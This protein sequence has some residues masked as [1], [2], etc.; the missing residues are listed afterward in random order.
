MSRYFWLLYF[1]CI[2]I[3]DINPQAPV[4]F[5]VIPKKEIRKITDATDEDEQVCTYH[6]VCFKYI[7]LL[8]FIWLLCLR[9]KVLLLLQV[10]F[11]GRVNYLIPLER[12]YP[13]QEFGWVCAMGTLNPLA[14]YYRVK[15]LK[16][17]HSWDQCNSIWVPCEG[18]LEGISHHYSMQ[19][20]S[21]PI[22]RG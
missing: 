13:D 7:Y 15:P 14:H 5:L 21:C 11:T 12:C 22:A 16:S 10:K 17:W 3:E 19:R 18:I 2:A 8:I 4:H 6:F 1:Q 20:K 9:I